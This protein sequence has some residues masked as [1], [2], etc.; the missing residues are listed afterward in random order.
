MMYDQYDQKGPFYWKWN[1]DPAIAWPFDGGHLI[2]YMRDEETWTPG[3]GATRAECVRDGIRLSK[4]EFEREFGV[5][6]R[7]LP[8]PEGP[9]S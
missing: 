3:S 1:K 8:T 5:I 4:E 7:D 2:F 9:S 6:G